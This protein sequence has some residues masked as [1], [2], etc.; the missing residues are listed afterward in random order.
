MTDRA[1]AERMAARR[2]QLR[3]DKS[4]L[5]R[6]ILLRNSSRAPKQG[7]LAGKGVVGQDP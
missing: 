6:E 1:E 7:D 5:L 3:R 2:A 4:D